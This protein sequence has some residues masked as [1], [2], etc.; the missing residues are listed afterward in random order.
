MENERTG[1]GVAVQIVPHEHSDV[2]FLQGQGFGL[3]P[4]AKT[5]VNAS[6]TE[7]PQTESP[8]TQPLSLM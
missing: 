3:E 4:F 8:V 6:R 5:I 7:P 1:A 2:Q